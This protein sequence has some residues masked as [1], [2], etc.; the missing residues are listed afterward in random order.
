MHYAQQGVTKAL[1]ASLVQPLGPL[2]GGDILRPLSGDFHQSL[3]FGDPTARAVLRSGEALSPG[4]ERL[5]QPAFPFRQLTAAADPQPGI[6]WIR[7]I[8]C[9]V[10]Q[11]GRFLVDPLAATQLRE[12]RRKAQ[13][14]L[15]QVEDVLDG[16]LQLRFG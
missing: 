6:L 11:L 14:D 2:Q 4:R 12:A 16:I 8:Q 7:V 15:A 3:I 1:R 5:Q 10:D 13:E 9:G